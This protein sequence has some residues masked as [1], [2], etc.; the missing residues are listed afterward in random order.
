MATLAEI[1]QTEQAI[2][3]KID[4]LSAKVDALKQG[5]ADPATLQAIADVQ[6]ANAAKLDT[7]NA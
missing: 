4:A 3:A 5:Q 1:L 7:L 2:G 6:A